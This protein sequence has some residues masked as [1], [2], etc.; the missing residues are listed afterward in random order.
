MSKI[1]EIL[2]A[3]R[4]QIQDHL[5]LPWSFTLTLTTI[6]LTSFVLGILKDLWLKSTQ[7]IQWD[8]TLVKEYY[9]GSSKGTISAHV[10][11]CLWPLALNID[12]VYPLMRFNMSAKFDEDSYLYMYNG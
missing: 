8:P 1:S 9:K 3:R 6:S 12:K 10:H 2:V 11:I 4:S 7:T 5:K